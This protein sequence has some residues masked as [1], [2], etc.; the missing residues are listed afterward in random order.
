MNKHFD[1][2]RW[3]KGTLLSIFLANFLQFFTPIEAQVRLSFD[4]PKHIFNV[5]EKITVRIG[6]NT[7]GV[8]T[9]SIFFDPRNPNSEIQKGTFNAAPG[10]DA[11]INFSLSAPG[12]VFIRATQSGTDIACAAVTPLSIQP[13]ESEPTDFDAFWT[14]QKQALSQIP[15]NPRMT[16]LNILPSGAKVFLLELDNIDN[17]KVYGYLS[18]PAGTGPFPAVVSL[19][20]F[21]DAPVQPEPLMMTDFADRCN[22]INLYINAHN[23]PPNETDPNAYKPEDLSKKDGFYARTM[24]LSSIRAI[25]YLASRPDFNGS[26]GVSGMSQGG[27]WTIQLAG[28]D[29]RVTAAMPINPAFCEQD[30]WRF[31]RASGFPNYVLIGKNLNID[32]NKTLTNMRYYDAVHFMKRYRGALMFQVGYEDD[33]TPA[34]TQLATYNQYRGSS[35]LLTMRE[36]GHTYPF[37]EYFLGRYAFF[38]QHLT[39]FKNPFNFK[40][41]FSAD[42]GLDRAVKDTAILE[43][44]FLV[45]NEKNKVNNVQWSKIEGVGK[46]SFQTENGKMVARFSQKGKYLLRVTADFDYKLADPLVASYYTLTDF[47]TLEVGEGSNINECDSDKEAPK[48]TGC[49]QNFALTTMG[50]SVVAKWTPPTA[51]DNCGTPSVSSNFLPTQSLPIGSTKV[52]YRATDVQ[53]N[54]A[55]CSFTIVV[56]KGDSSAPSFKNDL[57]VSLTSTA[58]T[59]RPYSFTTFKV[60]IENKSLR[61]FTDIQVQIPFPSGFVTGGVA[62]AT[63]GEWQEWC[64]NGLQCS[65]WS[66]PQLLTGEEATLSLPVYIGNVTTSVTASA[67]LIS[68]SPDDADVSNN[69]A[70]LILDLSSAETIDENQMRRENIDFLVREI[71]PTLT[72]YEVNLI[73]TSLKDR[74]V[75]LDVFGLNGVL[76]WSQK[77]KV[78]KGTNR[79]TLPVYDLAQGLYVIHLKPDGLKPTSYKFVKY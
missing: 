29:K 19:P 66:I 3:R 27:G 9:Y 78:E 37:D 67:R 36:R 38:E 11:V 55:E 35:T 56:T 49:P 2:T 71:V 39:G 6:S 64:S 7:A 75:T 52:I 57:A 15:I 76:L 28:L 33:V 26:L 8:G 59:P 68:S 24:I 79:V 31:D 74:D 23:A 43:P 45:N 10:S 32:S 58:K 17:R 50:T 20:P 70:T 16:L 63:L 21:G 72:D 40:E 51:T 61:T 12:M 42:A 65:T 30:G 47:I 77:Q 54:A 60:K 46:V 53:Q 62:S 69:T 25:D 41:K 22:S 34:A 44:L 18:V 5:G 48:F 13:F 4:N 14:Q 1:Q 73:M